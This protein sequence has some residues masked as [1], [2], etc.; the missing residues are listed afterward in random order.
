MKLNVNDMTYSHC[1]ATIEGTVKK[2]KG[3]KK[4]KIDLK[5]KEVEIAG[6]FP[7]EEVIKV[8]QNAGY[9]PLEIS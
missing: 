6:D 7:K 5:T 9:T 2:I 4:V 3:V 8:I 1:V